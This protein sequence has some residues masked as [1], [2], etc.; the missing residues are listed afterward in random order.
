MEPE[1]V[2]S[3][4][5]NPSPGGRAAGPSSGATHPPQWSYHANENVD[6]MR[7][8]YLKGPSDFSLYV[9]NWFGQR[10]ETDTGYFNVRFDRYSGVNIELIPVWI[11]EEKVAD[12]GEIITNQIQK[13]KIVT[14]QDLCLTLLVDYGSGYHESIISLRDHLVS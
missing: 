14:G 9:T 12:N 11:K 3:S 4:S 7:S 6:R 8:G 13:V 2:D 5:L 1:N 10:Y